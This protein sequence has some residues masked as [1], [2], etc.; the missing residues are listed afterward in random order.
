MLDVARAKCAHFGHPVLFRQLD[1]DG[2]ELPDASFDLVTC[3]RLFHHLDSGERERILRELHRQARKLVA[4]WDQIDV[5]L[6]PT[7]T[8]P[9]PKLGTIGQDVDTA[10]DQFLDWLSFTHPFN[11]TGQPAISLPLAV[12]TS[13]LPI[14]IQLVGQPHDEYTILSLGAQLEAA[15]AKS[16]SPLAGEGRGGRY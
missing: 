6:T 13:G 7:L 2:L 10:S 16:P 12:S 15:V 5:L 3:I 1:L 8:Y 4:S 9:A 11:C 14:G